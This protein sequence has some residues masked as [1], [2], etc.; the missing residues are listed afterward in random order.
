MR[1]GETKGNSK[2][3]KAMFLLFPF[4]TYQ[5]PSS[6][7]GALTQKLQHNPL[8]VML[9]SS[10]ASTTQKTV[11][12][13]RNVGSWKAEPWREDRRNVL[14][15]KIEFKTKKAIRQW[16]QIRCLLHPG[17]NVPNLPYHKINLVHLVKKYPG[18]TLS[19]SVN[20]G[21]SHNSSNL[22]LQKILGFYSV[23]LLGISN[24]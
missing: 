2:R 11:K 20:P 14:C 23:L 22:W 15:N 1:K 24:V 18:F 17:L 9:W 3:R 8:K 7:W 4:L 10:V 21:D 6:T 12:N 13:S 16:M 19:C 5:V